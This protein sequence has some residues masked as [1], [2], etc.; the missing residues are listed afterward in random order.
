MEPVVRF[1]CIGL[2]YGDVGH[3]I[4]EDDSMTVRQLTAHG[5]DHVVRVARK[6]DS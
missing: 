2:L 5:A 6:G 3:Q 1:V 4:S